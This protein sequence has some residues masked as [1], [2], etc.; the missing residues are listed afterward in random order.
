MQT[1]NGIEGGVDYSTDLFDSTTVR[2]L[3]ARFQRLLEQAVSRPQTKLSDFN[4]LT[5]EETESVL[6]AW[7]V[8]QADYPRDK[9]IVELFEQQVQEQPENVA[10]L[11]GN[12]QVSYGELN[13][14][15]NRLARRLRAQGI[16]RDCL[17]PICAPR[18]PALVI[19]MLG[20][21]KAGGGYVPIDSAQPQ[22]RIDLL[23][24]AVD[25]RVVLAQSCDADLFAAKY[26]LIE[27][28]GVT[29]L[30]SGDS[31]DNFTDK[32]KAGDLAYVNFTSGSTGVPKG[33]EIRHRSVAR[34]VSATDYVQLDGDQ[35]LVHLSAP[36]FDATTF[37]I[38]AA[39]LSGAR[40]VLL[41]DAVTSTRVLEETFK[42]YQVTTVFLTTALFNAIVDECPD[43]LSEV[44]QLLTGGEAMSVEH[45]RRALKR[46]PNLKLSNIY[47]PTEATTFACS[48]RIPRDL[49]AAIRSVPIGRPISNTSAYVLDPNLQ[50]VPV[51]APGELCIAG[52][53]LARGYLNQPELTSQRFVWTD[54]HG[55]RQRLFRTGD[56]VRWLADGNLE[57]LGRLDSQ[58]KI[59]GFRIEPR[60]VEVT[61]TGH[62]EVADAVVMAREDRP[63]EKR[64]V[65]YFV[66]REGCRPTEEAIRNYMKGVLPG[67]MIP[68]CFV[69]LPQIP[70]TAHGKTDHRRLPPPQL[71]RDE[72]GSH[73]T[74]PS[75]S[76]EKGLARIWKALLEIDEIGVHEDFFDLG[77]H[78]LLA[79]RMFA[80]IENRF[81]T[82]LPL[83]LLF[84]NPTIAALSKLI[85]NEA[86]TRPLSWLTEMRSGGDRRPVYF[87][88][89][90][91]GE[92]AYCHAIVQHLAPD[93]P[94]YAIN[95]SVGE[96]FE[97]IDS[98]ERMAR[99]HARMLADAHGG[100]PVRLAGYSFGGMLAYELARQLEQQGHQV[101]RLVIIDTGW[102]KHTNARMSRFLMKVL[103]CLQNLPCWLHE[104]LADGGLQ[105]LRKNGTRK[106]RTIARRLK[107]W[108]RSET[109]P[110]DEVLNEVAGVEDQRRDAMQ[111]HLNAVYRYE[112]DGLEGC[113]T[114]VRSRARPLFHSFEHDLGWG[115]RAQGGA[116]VRVVPGNHVSI[117]KPPR[118]AGLGKEIQS[119]L[120]GD[121]PQR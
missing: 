10:L 82:R 4:L 14:M 62:P 28:D 53:G 44:K 47:G 65:A 79:A 59:R 108:Q 112:P 90:L 121:G 69:L 20:I 116:E 88:H 1:R 92:A 48:Y 40:T 94:V 22:Q 54:L 91:D 60:E 45:V 46:F 98:I 29:E 113:V 38:W 55:Q 30:G 81:G 84:R 41:P 51:G 33:V 73:G 105:G 63:G 17:V 95:L 93:Q 7:A 87:L 8:N 58:V 12:E 42:K 106:L 104:Q 27:L 111:R 9:S 35:V 120:D 67:Y 2:Q 16:G 78:S 109:T 83:A 56:R 118:V 61:L 52:D 36:S 57:F 89:G 102:A 96:P 37:E 75:T 64:L 74:P 11:A 32:P 97:R 31:C 50:P 114:L 3:I 110:L 39:L 107:F 66:A 72:V 117:L 119:V 15:S 25:S 70:I 19:G 86:M 23:L 18:S 80:R 68:A 100:G 43:A 77:G 71:L 21:L 49:P 26:E 103:R 99:V 85:E 6:S 101:D 13:E 34:L 5:A 24:D 115:D 76:T